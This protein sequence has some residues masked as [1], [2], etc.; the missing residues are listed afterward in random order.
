MED[1]Q[2]PLPKGWI[3]QFDDK[4]H[5]QFF[6]DTNADPPRAVWTHPYDDDTYL[7]SLSSDERERIQED[8]RER[9]EDAR[10]T[11]SMEHEGS[12]HDAHNSAKASASAAG[13]DSAQLPPRPDPKDG[14]K[15]FGRKL[16]DKVTGSTHEERQQD[17]ARKA[18]EERQYY[19]AHQ[20]FRR[21]LQK[22]Q[23]TGEPQFLAKDKDGKDVYIEP[24]GGPGA[25]GYGNNGGYGFSAY[26]AGI[27]ALPNTRFIR[28]QMPYQ[29]PYGYGGGYG[30]YGYDPYYGRGY[31]GGGY[32]LPVAGGLLGGLLLGGLLF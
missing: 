4:E 29:R 25:A 17:R 16:K 23:M 5:H 15:T 30:G 27:Y 1:E 12:S 6:V 7:R 20:A 10:S 3:R 24:P 21:A 8:E 31:G 28:P 11:S 2:R 18:E 22:A 9:L 13:Y 19:E 26:A 14:K 32:G